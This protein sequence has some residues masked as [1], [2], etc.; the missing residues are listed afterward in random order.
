MLQYQITTSKSGNKSL[1]LVDGNK[2]IRLHS[3]YDPLKEAIRAAEEFNPGRAGIIVVCGLA[4]GYHI[5][6][7]Q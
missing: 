5:I 7:L 2:V 4:L 3:A 6:A 1:Q